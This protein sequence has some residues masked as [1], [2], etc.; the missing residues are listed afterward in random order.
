[1]KTKLEVLKEVQVELERFT[2]KL[3]LAIKAQEKDKWSCKDYAA[4]KRSAMDLKR[5][6]TKL[7]QDSK[8]RW[9]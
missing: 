9:V 6:L 7:T 2:N 3:N 5:E 8:Y 4:A 1:M